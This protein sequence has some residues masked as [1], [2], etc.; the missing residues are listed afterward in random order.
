MNIEI[1]NKEF[2]RPGLL[3][4]LVCLTFDIVIDNVFDE[5]FNTYAK[6]LIFFGLAF[7]CYYPLCF[8]KAVRIENSILK[9]GI[10]NTVFGFVKIKNQILLSEVTEV[11]MKQSDDKFFQIIVFSDNN[12]IVL[13]KIANRIPAEEELERLKLLIKKMKLQN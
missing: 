1:E 8:S 12:Q 9:F 11:N 3:A 5:K 2:I 10:Y 13:K 4:C 6:I 7:V